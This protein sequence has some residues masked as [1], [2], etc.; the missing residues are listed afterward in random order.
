[1]RW[2]TLY[3]RSRGVPIALAIAAGSTIVLWTL[4]SLFS[5]SRDAGGPMV[6]LSVLILVA[7]ASTTL[8]GP[9]EALDRTA[10]LSWWPRRA[11]HVLAALAVIQ[12][13]LLVTLPTGARFGPAALVLRDA[14]GLL[15]MAA[16]G[17]AT[18]GA[19]RAWFLP[20]GWT[21]AVIVFPAMDGTAGHILTWQSQATD[22]KVAAATALGLA[23]TGLL[24]YALAGPLRRA[25]A[26]AAL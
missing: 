8:A 26:E 11:A 5:D 18:I 4:W 3:L 10:A 13:L 17:A 21:L 16:L 2:L 24:A 9:D 22:N 1:M 25:P 23:V 20:L 12:L 14:A 19:S 6:I 7:V 15:G